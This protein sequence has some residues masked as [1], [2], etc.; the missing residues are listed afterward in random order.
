MS[1]EPPL[2]AEIVD[3]WRAAGRKA[4]YRHDEAFDAEIRDRFEGA[5]H[6]AARGEFADWAG[7]AEG[8]LALLILLDQFPRNL[9]RGSAHSYATDGLA[10][11]IASHAVDAGLDQAVEPTLRPFVYMPFEHSEAMA[12]QERALAL[13]TAQGDEDFTRY[14]RLHAD[15]IRR[16]GRFPHRN[17]ALG[18]IS[19]SDEIAF[20]AEGGFAG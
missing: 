14:A 12:D 5:H 8:A 9:F 19:T 15:I 4:W 10:C 2:Y 18:R 13:F 3:F 16:F 1:I 17:A 11:S 20:L 6:A 7:H